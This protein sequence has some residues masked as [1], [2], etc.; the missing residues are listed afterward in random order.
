MILKLFEYNNIMFYCHVN[1]IGIYGQ[2]VAGLCF[3]FICIFNFN[4][5]LW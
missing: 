2:M 1:I 5:I 4:S 3:I